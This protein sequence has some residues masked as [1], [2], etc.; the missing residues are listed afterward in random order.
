MASCGS[1]DD[2]TPG[3]DPTPGES[4]GDLCALVKWENSSITYFMNLDGYLLYQPGREPRADCQI[5]SSYF[6]LKFDESGQLLS[7]NGSLLRMYTVS[8]EDEGKEGS[9]TLYVTAYGKS[10]TLTTSDAE[11]SKSPRRMDAFAVN[12]GYWID[13]MDIT[14]LQMRGLEKSLAIEAEMKGKQG[15]LD[16]GDASRESIKK[17]L[18]L[19]RMMNR[20]MRLTDKNSAPVASSIEYAVPSK[21][22]VAY[23]VG[24]TLDSSSSLHTDASQVIG[25]FQKWKSDIEGG[26]EALVNSR[27]DRARRPMLLFGIG[28]SALPADT[29]CTVQ[30]TGEL[31]SVNN[32]NYENF[33]YGVCVTEAGTT[34]TK[35]DLHKIGKF[36][37]G[38][39]T[40]LK[41]I[42]LPEQYVVEGLKP[43]TEY[44]CRFYCQSWRDH[45]YIMEERETRFTT[46]AQLDCKNDAAIRVLGATY[47]TY[48]QLAEFTCLA[49]ATKPA[50]DHISD[51]GVC[52]GT[53]FCPVSSLDAS[54][55]ESDKTFVVPVVKS[56]FSHIDAASHQ[57]TAVVPVSIWVRLEGENFKRISTPRDVT[58]V[59]DQPTSVT[60]STDCERTVGQNSTDYIKAEDGTWKHVE[61]VGMPWVYYRVKYQVTGALFIDKI[62]LVGNEYEYGPTSNYKNGLV[63]SGIAKESEQMADFNDGENTV[64]ISNVECPSGSYSIEGKSH[65]ADARQDNWRWIMFRTNGQAHATER[66]VHYLTFVQTSFKFTSD[67]AQE[68]ETFM[69][70]G[71]Y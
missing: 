61:L 60:I 9:S 17:F 18:A 28:T 14:L 67:Y 11:N 32:N 38:R 16:H 66:A 8:G 65:Q 68:Y 52:V 70:R 41:A 47:H 49:T 39:G 43:G 54:D 69:A 53:E 24:G 56:A 42:S 12:K 55:Q 6:H 23:A 63:Y 34:P 40:G 22:H 35:A 31:L 37:A 58:L 44:T 26:C 1:T 7:I 51:W 21:G 29:T 50:L 3:P 62:D 5:D 30:I 71:G 27:T 64:E 15:V 57:A 46:N 48:G 33:S 13:G 19:A 36:E 2:P 4:T 59:Y 20:Y 10:F 45:T 25:L